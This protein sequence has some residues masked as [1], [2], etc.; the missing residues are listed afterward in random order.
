MTHPAR[1]RF[2]YA[3]DYSSRL[4][5]VPGERN[6]GGYADVFQYC[7]TLNGTIYAV[8]EL[9]ALRGHLAEHLTLSRVGAIFA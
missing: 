3:V 6:G 1:P 8:K 2:P 7:D 4:R 9:K 5:K